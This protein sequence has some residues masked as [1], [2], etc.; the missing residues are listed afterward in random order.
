MEGV[1]LLEILIWAS[2]NKSGILIPFC[3]QSQKQ[4]SCQNSFVD[5]GRI[6]D[7]HCFKLSFHNLIH[8]HVWYSKGDICIILG[9]YSVHNN[10]GFLRRTIVLYQ[11]NFW[12]ILGSGFHRRSFVVQPIQSF[13][14]YWR[15]LVKGEQLFFYHPQLI[16]ANFYSY[17][18]VVFVGE[19]LFYFRQYNVQFNVVVWRLS[20]EHNGRIICSDNLS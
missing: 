10:R 1:S 17:C 7:H 18:C 4:Q 15:E 16:P 9:N 14:S 12:Y 11:A 2:R 8:I 20:E 5:I 19:H 3:L 6:D 13:G